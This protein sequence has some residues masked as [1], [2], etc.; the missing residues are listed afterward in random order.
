[1][2]LHA[3]LSRMLQLKDM[4]G[5]L[6]GMGMEPLGGTPEEFAADILADRKRWAAVIRD[7]GVPTR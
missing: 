2:R 5:Q 3:E 6:A 4:R 7:A 1:M